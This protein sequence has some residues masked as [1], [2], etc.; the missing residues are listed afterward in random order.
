MDEIEQNVSKP[1][2]I[3]RNY[4]SF[5]GAAI[6]LASLAS[7][8]L[9]FLIEITSKGENPYLGILTYIILPSILIFGLMVIGIGGALERRRRRRAS[10]EDV[11]AYPSLDLNNPHARRAFLTFLCIVVVFLAASAF[12]SYRAFE[13]TESVSFCG[14]T[15]NVMKP[16]HTA[17]LAGAHACVGCVG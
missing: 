7:V 2:S 8:V 9:L 4:I 6:V 15:C 11:A 5:I 13:Y 10:P 1:P 16:E 12:G 17:Y 3:F 14:Q